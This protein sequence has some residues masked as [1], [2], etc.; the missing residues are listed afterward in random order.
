[1]ISSLRRLDYTRASALYKHC[2]G[3]CLCY[4]GGQAER[5][6]LIK[7]NLTVRVE[8][9]D[10]QLYTPN[11]SAASKLDSACLFVLFLFSC[12]PG[13]K[14]IPLICL[15]TLHTNSVNVALALGNP[16]P[17][18]NS[19]KK[20]ILW[21]LGVASCE[22]CRIILFCFAFSLATCSYAKMPNPHFVWKNGNVERCEWCML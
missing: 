6:K 3:L 9:S 13:Y 22:V 18:P 11:H 1:M 8:T 16:S 15:I 20:K 21:R 19:Q 14:F 7:A 10:A 12:T 17:I 4:A 5:D 2:P